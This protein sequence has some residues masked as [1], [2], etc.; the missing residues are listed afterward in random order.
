MARNRRDTLDALTRH[1]VFASMAA[2]AGPLGKEFAY[3]R[4]RCSEEFWFPATLARG[5]APQTVVFR[6]T[7][8]PGGGLAVHASWQD[9]MPAAARRDTLTTIMA[10]RLARRED[11]TPA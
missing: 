6:V 2:A 11:G 5:P 8:A 1:A 4:V 9:R 10:R 7:H 3:R